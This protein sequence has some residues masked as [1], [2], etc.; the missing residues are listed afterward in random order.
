MMQPQFSAVKHQRHYCPEPSGLALQLLELNKAVAFFTGRRSSSLLEPPSWL[1][2]RFWKCLCFSPPCIESSSVACFGWWNEGEA[3]PVIWWNVE[4]GHF[5]VLFL[6]VKVSFPEVGCLLIEEAVLV[7]ITLAVIEM[8]L[9][10]MNI[11]SWSFVCW[12]HLYSGCP[13][14]AKQ[15]CDLAAMFHCL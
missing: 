5:W 7:V 10:L 12:L 14:G 11:M 15:Q 6:G 13:L 8:I 2:Y 1:C 9:L 4:Y 3:F